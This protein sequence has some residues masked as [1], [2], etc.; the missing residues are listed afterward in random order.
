[1][2]NELSNLEKAAVVLMSLGSEKA[3]QVIAHLSEGEVKRLSRAFMAVQQVDREV[4]QEVNNEFLK[5]LHAADKL[6]VDGREFARDVIAGAFGN[7]AGD[8]LLDYITGSKKEPLSTLIA[9]I[10]L[11]IAESFLGSEH[12]Q[13]VAFLLSK[14]KPE[15]AAEMMLTLPESVQAE[16]IL[17][18]ADLEPVKSDV[19]DDVREILRSQL[20]GV[21]L[22][23]E[24]EI[25][26]SK[27]VADI[28]NYVDRNN[29]ERIITELEEVNGDL[30]E[31]IRNL[32]FTFE[33]LL[34]LDDRAIQT[35]LKDVSKELLVLAMKQASEEVKELI[36]RNMSQRA[37]DMLRDDLE[38][39]P[40]AKLKDVERAQQ[41]CVDVV[42][43]LESEGKIQIAGG[44]DD[45][46]V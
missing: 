28:L 14:M 45:V 25:G 4:Q 3:A 30:A 21:S 38:T 29:E 5:M 1:M 32:M 24:E 35:V 20:R 6:V 12:P 46:L 44:G 31:E 7:D 27:A 41:S 18:I 37:A 26:G 23:Q 13:T 19:V 9:D 17:R 15:Q 8:S 39:A 16:V 33:D 11:S 2:A 40:P 34:R 36:L 43:K 42:R 10:P 22:R